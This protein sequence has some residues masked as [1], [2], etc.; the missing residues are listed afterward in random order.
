MISIRLADGYDMN[1]WRDAARR[2]VQA[3]LAPNMVMWGV[4]CETGDDLFGAS[5]L[6][7]RPHQ[8]QEVRA[9]KAFLRLAE[10][11]LLHTD[12]ERHAIL[13]D[14]LWRLQTDPLLINDASDPTIRRANL[15]A[16]AVGRDIH[17]MRAFVRFRKVQ[18]EDEKPHFLAW[19]E[20]QFPI[21]QA[22]AQFFIGR[23][24]NMR[25][26]ILTPYGSLHWDG[27]CLTKGPPAPRPEAPI[28]DDG[29]DL[30]RTYYAAIF[31]PA[32][33]KIGAMVKE[34][35]RRYWKNLPEATLIPALIAGAQA[36]EAAKV[37][38]RVDAFDT[39]PEPE[40]LADIACG[41]TQCRRCEIGC[42][43][44][45]AVM[46]EGK[47]KARIMVLGEA[48]GDT[49]EREGRPFV[50]P[51][52]ALLRH[53]LA[54]VGLSTEELYMTS[55]VKHFKFEYRDSPR[56]KMRLHQTPTSGEIDLCR[57]W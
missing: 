56:G 14:I 31:N 25:W 1:V 48:P 26:T 43:N 6:P 55:A 49:E 9:S 3:R 52:G 29:E 4:D 21:L 40:N 34:M 27:E 20:P 44:T 39:C 8:A 10:S 35:P 54:A 38:H 5:E 51:A 22:N 28:A 15:L 16:K 12:P 11:A 37:T 2:C 32:R 53:H 45:R 19:F 46:G 7:E 30:W 17:K 33:L 13:Y 24:A 23:F 42:N 57:W 47:E 18:D 36:R 50:G 41:I